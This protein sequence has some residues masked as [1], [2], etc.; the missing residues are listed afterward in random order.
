[1]KMKYIKSRLSYRRQWHV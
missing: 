1:M